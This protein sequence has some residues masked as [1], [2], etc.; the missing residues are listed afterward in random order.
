[1]V[2]VGRQKE[3]ITSLNMTNP[4]CLNRFDGSN[5]FSDLMCM[6]FLSVLL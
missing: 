2:A 4:I 1:M 3:P 6:K 5:T